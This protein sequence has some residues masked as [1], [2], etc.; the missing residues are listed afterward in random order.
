[1]LLPSVDL[2]RTV[3][4]KK[5]F[6]VRKGSYKLMVTKLAGSL[7]KDMLYDLDNDP[8]ELH[9]LLLHPNGTTME[10]VGKA[11]HLKCLL[12]EWME[13]M[14]GPGYYSGD[15]EWTD[16]VIGP[17]SDNIAGSAGDIEEVQMR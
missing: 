15:P 16:L 4:A 3:G 13:R 1:M 2:T 9:N 17:F 7:R 10:V 14:D 12:L 5:N 6:M 8:Y 11:E